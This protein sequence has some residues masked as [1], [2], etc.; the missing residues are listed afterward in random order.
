MPTS[1]EENRSV[2]LDNI[3]EEDANRLARKETRVQGP[4]NI[5]NAVINFTKV[6][7]YTTFVAEYAMVGEDLVFHF[8]LTPEMD[9]EPKDGPVAAY[10][11]VK[12]PKVLDTS[13]KKYFEAKSPRLVAKY[14]PE[15]QSW[16]MKAQGYSDRIDPD[17]FAKKFLEQLDGDLEL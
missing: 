10:W 5:S 1:S 8:F 6:K 3:S 7:D 11:M 16:W 9:R 17:A 14:T 2:V 4:M 15:M 13:A 12:F